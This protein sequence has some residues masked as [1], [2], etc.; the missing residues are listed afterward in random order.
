MKTKY[1][2]YTLLFITLVSLISYRV[3]ENQSEAS[4][5]GAGKG[6]GK[7][8]MA[9]PVN[10][11][12]VEPRAFA[13]ELSVTGSIEAN[14]QVQIR[15]QVSGIINGIFF[16]EGSWVN[17]GEVL[18]KIDDAELKAQL[19]QAQTKQNLARENERRA[20]LLLKKEAISQEEYEV[21]QSDL[22]A[23]SAQTQLIQAQLA[24]T[25]V[26]APFSG[27][28]GLRSVSAGEYLSPTTIVTNLV[29]TDPVKITFA[30]PEKYAGQVKVNTELNFTV[31]GSSQRHKAKVY[32]IEPSIDA[33]TR[34]LQLKATAKNADGALL[35]GSFANIT[36]PL[37][38][39]PD[40]ILIPTE[41]VI[42]IQNGK[43]VF[44]TEGGK[45]KEAFIETSARTDKY[46]LVTSGLQKG[47]TVLTTGV[48]SLKKGTP[49]KVN[50]EEHK[51]H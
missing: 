13:N 1:I 15:S 46:V 16:K 30:V 24:K 40:A 39:I 6:K 36:L 8:G 26:R 14:E 18:L 38:T 37:N 48:M 50:T 31:S 41:A 42:P 22:K 47:D 3:L 12:I 20:S 11:V 33:A 44:I 49:V 19:L 45:A 7:G 35:P 4:T 5:S 28:I 25:T 43:K 34:T 32:A 2:F 51:Q 27:K 29:N 23:M 21:A 10:G 17:K 9:M